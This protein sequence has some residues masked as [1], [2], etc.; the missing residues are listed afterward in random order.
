[1]QAAALIVAG[2]RDR[3][4]GF[5]Q[6]KIFIAKAKALGENI[7]NLI[8]ENEGHGIDKWPSK[9]K[10]AR[11]VGGFWTKHLGGRSGNWNWIEP[12]AAYPD[13]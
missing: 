2:K 5:E 1:M 11:R 10:R 4:V 13:K 9:V 3:V 12:V 8:F 7:D 6:T